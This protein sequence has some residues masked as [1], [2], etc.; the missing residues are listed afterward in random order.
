MGHNMEQYFSVK[1]KTNCLPC[2]QPL[3]P[4]S[5]HLLPSY[6]RLARCEVCHAVF[7]SES[8]LESHF[9][10]HVPQNSADVLSPSDCVST[11]GKVTGSDLTLPQLD[12]EHVEEN[13]GS[14]LRQVYNTE[15]TVTDFYSKVS[16]DKMP[17]LN[18][19]LLDYPSFDSLLYFPA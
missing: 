1:S 18:D 7:Q 19:H 4:F 8:E 3:P 15:H 5:R 2:R 12:Q 14:I 17:S 13:V 9:M 11:D 6:D 10:S 16:H